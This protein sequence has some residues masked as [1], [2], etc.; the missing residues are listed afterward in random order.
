M[1]PELGEDIFDMVLIDQ[2][3][4]FH[5]RLGGGTAVHGVQDLLLVAQGDLG[6]GDK[7]GRDQGVGFTAFL[8]EYTLDTEAYGMGKVFD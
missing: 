3:V 6:I 4:A 2:V 7:E 1:L 8:T 5:D